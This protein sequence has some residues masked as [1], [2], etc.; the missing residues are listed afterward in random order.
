MCGCY[1]FKLNIRAKSA[2]DNSRTAG[3]PSGEDAYDGHASKSPKSAHAFASLQTKF[4]ADSRAETARAN[5]SRE[6][7][8]AREPPSRAAATKSAAKLSTLEKSS[9]EGTAE[10]L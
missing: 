8:L 4:A 2:D 10:I 9:H 3:L 5:A 1:L 6:R 7:V